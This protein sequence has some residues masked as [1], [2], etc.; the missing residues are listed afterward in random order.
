MPKE[1]LQTNKRSYN[2]LAEN[3][4]KILCNYTFMP[5]DKDK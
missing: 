1:A 4:R 3:L 2:F 5:L